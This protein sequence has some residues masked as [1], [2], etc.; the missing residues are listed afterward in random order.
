MSLYRFDTQIS[1]SSID[2]ASEPSTR[3]LAKKPNALSRSG[4]SNM[5]SRETQKSKSSDRKSQPNLRKT[6]LRKDASVRQSA[7][8]SLKQ[9]EQS[10]TGTCRSLSW[11]QSNM[12]YFSSTRSHSLVNLRLQD[13]EFQNDLGRIQKAKEID[14]SEEISLSEEQRHQP[15]RTH[16]LISTNL[17]KELLDGRRDVEESAEEI[18]IEEDINGIQYRQKM[19]NVLREIPDIADLS[20]SSLSSIRDKPK[21]MP[22]K[23]VKKR[24]QLTINTDYKESDKD[25]YVTEEESPDTDN[26]TVN[27]VG[28][29]DATTS[30]TLSTSMLSFS[31]IDEKFLPPL[32][33]TTYRLSQ[34]KSQEIQHVID[35]MIRQTDNILI[36]DDDEA[37][38]REIYVNMCK[39]FVDDLIATV[40]T[41]YEEDQ[42]ALRSKLDK[43][44]LMDALQLLVLEL[45]DQRV[46]RD[47]LERM[48]SEHCFRKKKYVYISKVNFFDSLNYA[49]FQKALKQLD[50]H[51][52]LKKLTE[53]K[54][55][56]SVNELREELNERVYYSE[57]KIEDFENLVRATLMK[58]K[59]YQR[60][61][62]LI[63]Y[64]LKLMAKLRDDQSDMRLELFCM[65]HRY[66]DIQL[67][68]MRYRKE[69]KDID[70]DIFKEIF[71]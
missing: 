53:I 35:N 8:K 62:N 33:A 20:D 49:R 71:I 52:E 18:V 13:S 4:K 51:L 42:S 40:V 23:S 22:E 67:V 5:G 25:G 34:E 47:Q 15:R 68:S 46:K 31:D 44:K 59:D 12:S 11:S 21:P 26:Q 50:K 6:Q 36:L 48:I 17:E 10:E 60:L 54:I 2:T 64:Q 45:Y 66:A 61:N 24:K 3:T 30:S 7:K 55:K 37:A 43:E 29:T 70:I 9:S 14:K 27:E 32:Q 1:H 38:E 16:S 57:Q 58:N 56:D 65:Q 28:I 41:K 19:I 69:F 39:Q 63:T